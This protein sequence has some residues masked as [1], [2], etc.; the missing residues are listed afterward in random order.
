MIDE[1]TLSSAPIGKTL[2][3]LSLPTVLAQVINMLYN[4]V[5]RVYIGH[6]DVNGSLALTGV[7]VCLPL[8]MFI[9]AFSSFVATG[10]APRS[11]IFMGKGEKE[12]SE[13][14]LG[15]SVLLQAI[16]SLVLT[17]LL[18]AFNR[19]L[20]LAFGASSATID[21]ASSYM[22]IYA[23]GTV[24]VELTLGLNAFITAEGKTVVSMV[25]VL[26]GAILNIV[27]DPVF[28]FVFDMGVEGAAWA[29]IISQGVSCIICIIY[30]SLGKSSL[31]LKWSNVLRLDKL[32]LPSF[33][34]GLASFVMQSTESLISICF[35]SNLLK[36]G[37]DVAVGTMTICSSVM[38]MAM[39]PL[40]GIA[41]GA[42]PLT[43]FNYGKGNTERVKKCYRTLLTVSLIY[44]VSL[45]ALVELFPSFFASIFTSDEALILYAV[46]NIRIY[47]MM[48]GLM[49][50]L[51]SSQMTFVSIGSALSSVS[52]ALV[53]KI[54]L[55]IPLIYIMPAIYKTNQVRAVFMAEPVADLLAITFAFILFLSVFP[56]ALKEHKIR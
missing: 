30:L 7:G 16:I 35:N 21:Y 40:Q 47:L 52:I 11:S 24:F 8:I 36:Y 6:M 23:L 13:K 55:L 28:I 26:V 42:Q 34:L 1:N 22:T 10:S 54:V 27:L 45:W 39:L 32:I 2:F 12:K 51:I 20:L 5:D 18:V 44:S 33:A 3:R 15:E 53:R 31:K 49:G 17:A 56:K 9:S 29:T 46:P 25:V 43:S 41:Q 14:L 4:V 48:L 38:Q 19:P 37:G 50:I